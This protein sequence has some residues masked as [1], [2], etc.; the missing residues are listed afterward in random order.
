MDS[1]FR[2]ARERLE[3]VGVGEAGGEL[4]RRV[5]RSRDGE[6]PEWGGKGRQRGEEEW[7]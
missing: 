7:G 1:E 3:I 5:L 6:N 4:D 2:K